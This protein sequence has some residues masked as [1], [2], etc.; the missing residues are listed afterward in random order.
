MVEQHE[1]MNKKIKRRNQTKARE[2]ARWTHIISGSIMTVIQGTLCHR[3]GS[4]GFGSYALAAYSTHDT[5]VMLTLPASSLITVLSG[6][7]SSLSKISILIYSI[8]DT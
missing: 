1:R 5:S 7:T 3:T 8:Q 2:Q 6:P 4:Q